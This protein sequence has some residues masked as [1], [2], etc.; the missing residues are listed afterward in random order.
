MCE[1]TLVSV[2]MPAYRCA[3]Y[4]AQAVESALKQTHKNLEIVVIDDCSG[5]ET[6]AIAQALAGQDSRVRLLKNETNQGTAATRNRG[7]EE[8]KGEFI[9]FLDGDDCWQPDKM[10]RQLALLE[11]TGAGLCYTAYD[12]MDAEGQRTGKVY[13]V[14][15]Q[16]SQ[17]RLWQENVIGCSTALFRRSWVEGTVMRR[18]FFHEDYVFWLEMMKKGCPMVGINE[19]LTCYRTYPASRSGNKKR[20]ARNRWRIYRDFLGMNPIVAGFW[21]VQ[22]AMRGIIKHG[23]V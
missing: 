2:I 12:F 8:A 15:E 11:K 9:A 20:A 16:C 22:Y 14:P 10:A 17:K 18:E 13:Y 21:F 4:L 6:L 1:N 23:G 3:P 5:D 7:L 19:P